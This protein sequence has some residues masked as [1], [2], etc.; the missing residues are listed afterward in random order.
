M[1]FQ[2]L[3]ARY[4]A[5]HWRDLDPDASRHLDAFVALLEAEAVAGLGVPAEATAAEAVA[6][7]K[8]NED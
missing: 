3:K 2:A 7:P 1:D 5:Q 8:P 6:D 4:L